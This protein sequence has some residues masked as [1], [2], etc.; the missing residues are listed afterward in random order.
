MSEL[1]GLR[2]DF[3]PS[4][5]RGLISWTLGNVAMLRGDVLQGLREHD[6]AAQLLRPE[7]D[8]R[9]W[10]RF[11]K[12]SAAMRISAGTDDG[13]DDLLAKATHALEL[14]GNQGDR[15]ELTLTRAELAL[16][17]GQ[18]RKAAELL[19]H[20]PMD[21]LPPLAL[22][23]LSWLRHRAHAALGERELAIGR[24]PRPRR[25]SRRPERCPRHSR[26]G[27]PSALHTDPR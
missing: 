16:T 5:L 15:L 26:P 19:R 2:E 17:R 18:S 21:G 4:H 8:L 24:R 13:V 22:A 6:E 25:R 9:A 20:T 3:A 12:A 11:C 10:G 27:G 7:T 1:A 23:E 14:V